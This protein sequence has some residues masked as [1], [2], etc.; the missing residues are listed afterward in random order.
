[1]D[2][3]F[4]DRLQEVI[5][6]RTF[7]KRGGLALA[8]LFSL[9]LLGRGY[10]P[11]QAFSPE[12]LPATHGRMVSDDV[13]LYDRPSFS[14]NFIRN[15][16]QDLVLPIDEATLGDEEPAYNRIWYRMGEGYIHSGS[17]QPV[18]VET[19]PVQTSLPPEGR[20]AEVTV[21]YTDAIK[22]LNFPSTVKYRLVY[23]TTY[24]VTRV[25]QDAAGTY[26][27][28]IDDDK[29]DI[30]YYVNASH[31][32]LVTPEDIS[33]LSPLVPPAA[34]RIEIRLAD[35]LVIAYENSWPVFV[36]RAATG[37]KFS[38]GDFRTPPGRYYTG[39]K[40][41]SRHMAA[42]DR[43]APNSYDLPGVPWICYLTEDGISF[44]GTYWHNDFGK[45]RSHGCI[46]VSAA[47]ALWIYRWTTPNV[48]YGAVRY[49]E[50]NGTAVDVIGAD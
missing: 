8:S 13:P 25:V 35:Q 12:D 7:L 1:M 29:Y 10:K 14:G 28:R 49:S 4:G 18:R 37:A 41:P 27:Y 42:G 21:P 6:R 36:C 31:L 40:R 45:P 48:P 17:V 26:Y 33:L 38:N 16:W 32:R 5:S 34:K 43:A 39:R 44:H 11:G 50:D 2:A 9:A 20:L 15:Y 24:W 30:H 3:L 19:N 46:N 22:W 23:S 47:A